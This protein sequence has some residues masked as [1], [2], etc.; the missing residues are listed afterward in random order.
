MQEIRQYDAWP[1]CKCFVCSSEGISCVFVASLTYLLMLYCNMGNIC[2]VVSVGEKPA[3]PPHQPIKGCRGDIFA[4]YR[5]GNV[6]GSGKFSVVRKATLIANAN[7]R[8]AVK[9]INKIKV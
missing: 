8:Y 3:I 4:N 7:L 6:I 5:F 2:C 1:W 9:L